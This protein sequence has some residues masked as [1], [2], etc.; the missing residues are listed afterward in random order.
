M[1]GKQDRVPR[2][3]KGTGRWGP[4]LLFGLIGPGNLVGSGPMRR[5]GC[6][7]FIGSLWLQGLPPIP[8]YSPAHA[9]ENVCTPLQEGHNLGRSPFWLPLVPESPVPSPSPRPVWSGPPSAWI[10]STSHHRRPILL[11]S[12][13]LVHPLGPWHSLFLLS[14]MP[15][16]S[17]SP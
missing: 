17:L 9:F 11:G 6:Q 14:G 16:S 2:V 1:L 7:P 4:S 8:S 10:P 13:Q 15:F 3:F 5:V 12:P